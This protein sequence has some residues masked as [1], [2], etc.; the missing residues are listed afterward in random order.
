MSLTQAVSLR[1]RQLMVGSAL[2][3]MASLSAC[4]GGSS[5]SGGGGVSSVPPAPSSPPSSAPAAPPPPPPA[6][7]TPA[8]GPT[9]FNT[10]EI[11]RS[12]GPAYHGAVTAWE[13]GATGEGVIVG[14]VDS[15]IDIDSHEFAGRIHPDSFDATLAQRGFDEAEPDGHGTR[16]ARV[17]AAARD[18]RDVVGVAFDATLLALRTDTGTSCT[19]GGG[20]DDGSSC[21]H[22]NS[23]VARAI[24][25]ATDVGARVIN[26]SLG[27]PSG[28]SSALR[29]A[30]DR[31]TRAGIVIVVSAGN[32]RGADD[33]RYD[34]SNPSPFAEGIV[35]AGNGLVIVST[36]VDE[37]D[38]ISDFSNRAGRTQAS[39]LSSLGDLVCCTFENDTIRTETR[40]DGSRV[41]SGSAGTSFSAPQISGAAA[42][43]VQAFPNLSGAE[44]VELLLETARDVGDQGVDAT[45]GHG[46]LDIAAAFRPVGQTSLSVN[47]PGG[48]SSVSLDSLSGSVSPAMGD[49]AIAG[50]AVNAIVTDRFNRPFNVDL[51][52][53]LDTQAP[54]QL[55]TPALT[56]TGQ[57]IQTDV[58]GAN[59]AFNISR[60]S[61]AP[62]SDQRA[63]ITPLNLNEAHTRGARLL[64]GRISAN[65][66][67]STRFSA[68][69]R[70]SAAHQVAALQGTQRSGAFVVSKNAL[71][72]SGFAAVPASSF[73]VR[74]QLGR[75]GITASAENGN[76]QIFD[77]RRNLFSRKDVKRAGYSRLSISADRKLGPANIAVTANWL[78]EDSTILG[79]SFSDALGQGGADSLFLSANFS[80]AFGDGWSASAGWKQGWSWAEQS[81]VIASGSQLASNAFSLELGK[82]GAFFGADQIG[83]R[84]SQPLR[85]AG[86]GLNLDLP[87]A[88]DFASETA[89]FG[90][91]HFNLAPQGREIASELAWTM[92]FAGGSFSTNAFW[93]QEPSHFEN[94][95]DDMGVAFRLNME[96]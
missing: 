60:N 20:S 7:A 14:L 58:A 80:A 39:V 10:S 3:A 25:R 27:G 91:R 46:I 59:I 5:S 6:P 77:A 45:F 86:G 64:A 54:A 9:N 33:P 29:S 71:S 78:G 16:V 70:Q 52:A 87:V 48:N 21:S 94:L 32:E 56:G 37:R 8:S 69:I 79:A 28:I 84:I 74:Q 23:D 44:I 31:A 93:R 55:L 90:I 50:N 95:P 92:S 82:R 2:A 42:L 65:I 49:A 22:R 36:S 66:A 43:L 26:I 40:A 24:N 68:A 15:G 41:A 19:D 34:P 17:L 62:I 67:K 89:E 61:F 11:R 1:K 88:F 51:S 4:G 83:L 38:R 81:D 13:E 76:T 73:A 18:D 75:L 47:T 72:D 53:A 57:L 30:V 12:D 96:F 85:V 63:G 35:D